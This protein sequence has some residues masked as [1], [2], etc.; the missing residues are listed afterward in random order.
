M[1]AGSEDDA[2]QTAIRAVWLKYRS[3]NRERLHALLEVREALTARML[4][5]EVRIHGAQEAHKLAGAA[6]SFGYEEVSNLC[7]TVEL[8]LRD[9]ENQLADVAAMITRIQALLEPTLE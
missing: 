4:V 1:T 7:R 5:S 6:G 2:L 3:L 9:P 8:A